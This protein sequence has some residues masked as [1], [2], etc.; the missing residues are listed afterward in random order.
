M[1][2]SFK[3]NDLFASIQAKPDAIGTQKDIS[4][5]QLKTLEHQLNNHLR[6]KQ[7]LKYEKVTLNNYTEDTSFNSNRFNDTINNEITTKFSKKKFSALPMCLRWKLVGEF[8]AIKGV[9]DPDKIAIIKGSI[10]QNK[11]TC[12]YDSENMKIISIP[13]FDIV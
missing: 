8:L 12:D 7:K 9:A 13:N 6:S 5:F 2:I 1:D 11:F 4:N 10:T 3:V